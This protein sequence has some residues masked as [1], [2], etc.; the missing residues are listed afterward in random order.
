MTIALPRHAQLTAELRTEI[1]SGRMPLGQRLPAE[2]DLAKIHGVS[3]ATLRRAL[4]ELEAEGLIGRRRRAGTVITSNQ[5]QKSL[6]VATSSFS[7]L[8]SLTKTSRL[9]ILGTRHVADDAC[10]ILAGRHSSTGY[11]LEITAERSLEAAGRPVSWLVMY[12]DGAFAGIEPLLISTGGAVFELVEELFSLKIARLSQT[13]TATACPEPAAESMGLRVGQP[14]IVLDAE[15]FDE[16]GRLVEISQAIY[17][18]SRF[19]MHMDVWM[20]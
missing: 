18:P 3:R 10:A 20:P 13:A 4:S 9:R 11:W 14:V 12:V 2:I 1:I 5:P 8:L 17:D 19:R 7:E 6:R 16:Q 15:L